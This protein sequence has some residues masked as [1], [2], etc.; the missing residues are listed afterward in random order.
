[1]HRL[2]ELQILHWFLGFVHLSANS[3]PFWAVCHILFCLNMPA[4]I[5]LY[6]GVLR[7]YSVVLGELR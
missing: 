6:I 7:H 3:H 2:G 5:V 4:G 1:M